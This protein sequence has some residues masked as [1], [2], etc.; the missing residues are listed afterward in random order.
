MKR[1]ATIFSP[2]FFALAGLLSQQ[3]PKLREGSR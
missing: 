1:L 3:T 2:C